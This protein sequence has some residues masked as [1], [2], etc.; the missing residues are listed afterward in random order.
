VGSIAEYSTF[1][2]K[3]MH[4]YVSTEHALII[5]HDG[6]ILNPAAWSDEFLAYDYIGAPFYVDGK[7]ITGN[8]GFSIRSSKLLKLTASDDRIDLADPAVH[9]VYGLNEDWIQCYI[10]REYLEQAGIR[11]APPE[12]AHRFSIESNELYGREWTGEFGFHGLR[13]T[14]IRPWLAQHPEYPIE[15]PLRNP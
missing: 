14:D 12:I 15:N 13:W 7:L 9:T 10:H 3:R 6:F 2:L 8:G 5:Q 1:I 4:E 11:F